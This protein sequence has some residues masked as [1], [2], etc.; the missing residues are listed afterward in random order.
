MV[1]KCDTILFPSTFHSLSLYFF[2][3]LSACADHIGVRATA[4]RRGI[5]RALQDFLCVSVAVREG[6]WQPQHRRH[7]SPQRIRASETPPPRISTGCP[8]GLRGTAPRHGLG[9]TRPS[10]PCCS[11]FSCAHRSGASP[12]RSYSSTTS[13]LPPSFDAQLSLPFSAAIPSTRPNPGSCCGSIPR[14]EL[15]RPQKKVPARA[16]TSPM[17]G[18]RP[19]FLWAVP[20]ECGEDTVLSGGSWGLSVP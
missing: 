7:T 11:E 3:S 9:A 4:S 8:P 1:L 19:C 5:P 6:L 13:P 10:Q 12:P 14:F 17:A 16:G 18:D 2:L 15:P 20:G